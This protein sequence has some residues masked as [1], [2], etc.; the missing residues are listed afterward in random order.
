[1]DDFANIESDIPIFKTSRH[2]SI[3]S[4]LRKRSW[5]FTDKYFNIESSLGTELPFTPKH[6]RLSEVYPNYQIHNNGSYEFNYHRNT[7]SLA[8]DNFVFALV[9]LQKYPKLLNKIF[10]H[11]QMQS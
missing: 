8:K 4:L 10:I 6:K 5:K 7:H 9:H 11:Q 1:M 2:R 3:V